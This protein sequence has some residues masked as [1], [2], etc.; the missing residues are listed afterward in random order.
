[1][2]NSIAEAWVMEGYE[3]T[4]I[5]LEERQIIVH[6]CEEGMSNL[7]IQNVLASGKLPGNAVYELETFMDYIINKYGLRGRR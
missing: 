6:R 2:Y 5:D 3:L 4:K 1:M 7:K